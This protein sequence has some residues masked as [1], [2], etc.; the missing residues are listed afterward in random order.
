MSETVPKSLKNWFIIHCVVDLFFAIPL[1]LFPETFVNLLQ[2]E[3]FDPLTTRLVAAALFGIGIES[4]LSRNAGLDKYLGMLRLKIIW[5]SF[6]FIGILWSAIQAPNL[7]LIAYLLA[8]V[9]L[10]FN[11]LWWYWYTKLKSR[12]SQV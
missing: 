8:G 1:F 10:A 7:S 4:Y 2:W 11:F 5:S 3:F 9:F 12:Q 6:A